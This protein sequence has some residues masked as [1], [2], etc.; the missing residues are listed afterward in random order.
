M[1]RSTTVAE[2]RI[3]SGVKPAMADRALARLYSTDAA[4][5]IQQNLDAMTD[6]VYAQLDKRYGA[7]DYAK[8]DVAD[9]PKIIKLWV[10]QLVAADIILISGVD[11]SAGDTVLYQTRAD[12]ARADIKLAADSVDG[13]FSLPLKADLKT[14]GI[15]KPG[16]V[17]YSETSPF[18]GQRR[19]AL[20]GRQE[21]AMGRGTYRGRR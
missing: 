4:D 21:D 16:F 10:S 6:W 2:F 13:M 1:A 12:R 7:L 9:V 19:A 18:V 11:A 3:L 17:S 14:G 5:A 15:V 20:R 8:L